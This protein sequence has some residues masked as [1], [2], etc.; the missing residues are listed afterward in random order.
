MSTDH[1]NYPTVVNMFL[2]NGLIDCIMAIEV[3]SIE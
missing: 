2:I 1:Y 3:I